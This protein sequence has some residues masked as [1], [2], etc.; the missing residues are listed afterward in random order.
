MHPIELTQLMKNIGQ[1]PYLVRDMLPEDILMK[2][3]NF[4]LKQ[5]DSERKEITQYSELKVSVRN[6]SF[7]WNFAEFYGFIH[8]DDET[9][10]RK[11]GCFR[12][13]SQYRFKRNER[14]NFDEK[15][16]NSTFYRVTDGLFE[17]LSRTRR[18]RQSEFLCIKW[19]RSCNCSVH[20]SLPHK[21]YFCGYA[22]K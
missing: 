18:H 10:A 17:T 14:T 5:A 8:I 15:S 12:R 9:I 22:A 4:H 21:N 6:S 1:K 13:N 19:R 20:A 3:L 16:C 7:H 2:W 11:N